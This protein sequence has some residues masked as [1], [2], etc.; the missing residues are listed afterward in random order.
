MWLMAVAHHLQHKGLAVLF[1]VVSACLGGEDGFGAK[2]AREL[3]QYS[4]SFAI[5]GEKIRVFATG[6]FDVAPHVDR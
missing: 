2:A 3:D 1:L 5:G 6:I 4:Q